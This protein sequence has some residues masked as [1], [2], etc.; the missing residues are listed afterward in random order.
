[1]SAEAGHPR[2]LKTVGPGPFVTTRHYEVQ[3]IQHTWRSREHR[4]GLQQALHR[5]SQSEW[6]P[7]ALNIWIGLGFV[8]GSILFVV[9]STLALH[10]PIATALALSE[11][12]INAVFFVGSIFFTAAAYLQLFQAANARPHPAEPRGTDQRVL[13]GWRPHE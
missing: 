2:I 1:M 3:G 7:E 4:R 13:I 5:E 6:Q 10:P 8:I 12:E 11:F 9:G